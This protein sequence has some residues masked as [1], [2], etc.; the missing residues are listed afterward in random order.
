MSRWV[1]SPLRAFL[2][3][4][5]QLPN[6]QADAVDLSILQQDNPTTRTKA[7]VRKTAA[8]MRA[9][10]AAPQRFFLSLEQVTDSEQHRIRV[11]RSIF[12]PP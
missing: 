1:Y 7:T 6:I 9:F 11:A 3:E 8:E 5:G 4:R 10:T 12:E 2:L